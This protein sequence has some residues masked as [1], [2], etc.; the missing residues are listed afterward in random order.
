[1]RKNQNLVDNASLKDKMLKLS[2][3]ILKRVKYFICLLSEKN[4]FLKDYIELCMN[5][6]EN[7]PEIECWTK[8]GETYYKEK[9]GEE[10][11]T[12]IVFDAI[13]TAR[14]KAV[15]E[16]GVGYGRN[17]KH[18]YESIGKEIRLH[19]VDFAETMLANAQEY[20]K[21]TGAELKWAD[22]T[23]KIPYPNDMFDVVF[24]SGVLQHISPDKIDRARAEM[25]RVSR[26]LVITAEAC[27]IDL[28]DGEPIIGRWFKNTFVS[29]DHAAGFQKLRC[30]ILNEQRPH[31][32][33]HAKVV[34][35]RKYEQ[36]GLGR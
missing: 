16:V 11:T 12:D 21:V 27:L 2:R 28:K 6:L 17:L 29:Y 33:I 26:N 14:P 9:R 15:L 32:N 4:I 24:S 35:V 31:D 7:I 30:E 3:C 10:P 1:M 20:L 5:R 36:D 8:W 18:I 22:I 23:D 34:V 13:K 19:G 25:V